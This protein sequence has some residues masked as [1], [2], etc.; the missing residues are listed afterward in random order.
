MR[1]YRLRQ[2]F[3]TVLGIGAASSLAGTAGASTSAVFAKHFLDKGAPMTI[4]E[5]VYDPELQM[6]V[7]P[8]TGQ[9]IYENNK[10]MKQ[11]KVTAGCGDCP[12]YDK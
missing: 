2:L 12:K 4:P 8:A 5:M 7:D 3:L 10:D 11:A 9:P 1:A 6:M